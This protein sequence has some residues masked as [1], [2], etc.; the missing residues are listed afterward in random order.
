[1]IYAR[2]SIAFFLADR[3]NLVH[4]KKT[5]LE[6]GSLILTACSAHHPDYLV[7]D[8][9]IRMAFYLGAH[10]YQIDG[11]LHLREIKMVDPKGYVPAGVFNTVIATK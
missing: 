11:N 2:V 6:D 5:H 7:N 10:A 8:E 1:M 3:E 4:F 9:A